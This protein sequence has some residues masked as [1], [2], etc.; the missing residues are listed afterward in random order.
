M[1]GS[2][3]SIDNLEAISKV[4]ADILQG[5]TIKYLRGK[6]VLIHFDGEERLKT[7]MDN[8][9]HILHYWIKNMRRWS[10][11]FRA[12]ERLVWIK[13][14]GV[15]LHGWSEELFSKIAGKWRQVLNSC[16][17]NLIEDENL[18]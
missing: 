14:V 17:N 4:V 9:C 11:G 1:F 5:S 16:N 15:P 6:Q 7:V 13:I 8:A 18:T 3:S 10:E 2:F 12:P